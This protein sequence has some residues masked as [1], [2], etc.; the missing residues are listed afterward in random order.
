M[1]S[2]LIHRRTAKTLAA[3]SD[4][5]ASLRLV[6]PKWDGHTGERIAEIL[7]RLLCQR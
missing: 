6:E 3:L 4:K 5:P 7:E 1:N 2:P